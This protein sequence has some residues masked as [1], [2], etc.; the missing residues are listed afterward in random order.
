LAK[1]VFD[2]A[3][4]QTMMFFEK[5]TGAKLK[6][7]LSEYG[8]FVVEEGQMG[9]AIGK[10]ASNVRKM[11]HLLKKNVI[12][13]EFNDDV[14]LFT[15]N[16]VYPAEVSDIKEENGLV[17]I[18]AKDAKSKGMIFGRER[19]RLKQIKEVLKRHFTIED[20]KVM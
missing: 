4:M 10:G 6:D 12:L 9:L 14:T 20:V 5:N 17:S 13:V 19:S 1:R 16:L 15:K 8:I 3:A 7:Y 2:I 11:E 18:H